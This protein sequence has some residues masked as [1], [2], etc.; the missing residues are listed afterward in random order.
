MIWNE[1]PKMGHLPKPLTSAIEA[2][3]EKAIW[4]MGDVAE[5]KFLQ[6]I[7]E[8][9]RCPANV[10][11]NAGTCHN[12]LDIK[13]SSVDMTHWIQPKIM[14]ENDNDDGSQ[15]RTCIFLGQVHGSKN[16][17]QTL[18]NYT[19]STAIVILNLAKMLVRLGWK[20]PTLKLL[21]AQGETLQDQC[22]CVC[23]LISTLHTWI[24]K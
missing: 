14:S 5:L 16:T 13:T 17:F 1:S 24:Y 11:S 23:V 20:D 21:L 22:V 2:W 9:M 8:Y 4:L 12:H 7:S 18:Y 19:H 15:K 10:P 6:A 3:E